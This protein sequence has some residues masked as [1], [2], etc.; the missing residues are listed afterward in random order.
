MSPTQIRL[1]QQSFTLIDPIKM[2]VGRSFH[3]RL[4]E[5][6]PQTRDLLN[7]DLDQRWLHL[8]GIF[9]SLMNSQLRSMLTLPATSTQS[10]EAVN[11]E[12]V[13]LA[14]NYLDHKINPEQ[15]DAVRQAL[16]WSLTRHLGDKLDEQTTEAW[17]KL[18]ELVLHSMTQI[19]SED[20]VQP[21]LPNRTGR[22]LTDHDDAGMEQLFLEPK[23]ETAPLD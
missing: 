5:V 15:M 17:S 22:T 9:Q 20:S 23:R 2:D 13:E 16:I 4:F 6:S 8:I 10:K 7:D 14:Q 21:S 11:L 18:I 1:L 19:M 12:I 3:Q